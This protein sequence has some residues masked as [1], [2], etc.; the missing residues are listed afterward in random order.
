M[1][2]AF[3][4]SLLA[5]LLSGCASHSNQ[6]PDGTWINQAAIDAAAEGGNLRQALL[7]YGPNLEWN[8][9]TKA[10]QAVA[11]N[12]FELSEGTI[13]S[14]VD[15]KLRVDFYGNTSDEL[16]IKGKDL[17][18][19]ASD[20]SPEQHFRAPKEAAP[21]GAQPGTSFE[22]ALYSAYIGGKWTIVSGEGQGSVVEFQPDGS[23]S[24]LPGNDRYALCL[25]G[26]CAAMSGEY[27]SMWLEKNERGNP[28]IF[29]RQGKQLEIFQAVNQAQA[30]EMPDLRP[31][32]R[33]WVLERK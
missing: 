24:G 32:E 9:N 2:V 5:A 11:S 10:H 14:N 21:V 18:Q 17:V 30:T 31:G 26:D 27:D 12:G 16:V 15:G 13:A 4:L 33:H 6:S 20:S 25:A 19:S 23:V 3:A 22:R 7:A 1:R 28:W 29:V 8:I